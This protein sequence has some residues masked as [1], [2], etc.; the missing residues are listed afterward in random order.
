MNLKSL[1]RLAKAVG[2]VVVP[3]VSVALPAIKKAVKE[4]KAR[5][6]RRVR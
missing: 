2:P 4:E 1:F 5:T 6:P 3:L